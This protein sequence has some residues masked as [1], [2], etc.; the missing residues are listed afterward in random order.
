M[1]DLVEKIN[2]DGISES[3]NVLELLFESLSS[4]V[5][6]MIAKQK[7]TVVLSSFLVLF[8]LFILL[9]F[10]EEGNTVHSIAIYRCL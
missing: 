4:L 6:T 10:T 5:K 7:A 1:L 9:P 3:L 8:I 2:K